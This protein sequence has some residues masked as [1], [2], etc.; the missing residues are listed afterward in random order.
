MRLDRS[1]MHWAYEYILVTA[2]DL[3]V[4]TSGILQLLSQRAQF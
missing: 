2:D 3:R 1:D 4:H